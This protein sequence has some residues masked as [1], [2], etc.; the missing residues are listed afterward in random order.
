MKCQCGNDKFYGHQ[1][2]K[3]DVIV[4]RCGYF[5]ENLPGG[6]EAS[7][8]DADQPY[9]PF[10]CTKCEKEYVD[11]EIENTYSIFNMKQSDIRNMGMSDI[12]GV[13]IN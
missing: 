1:I 2:I 3:A 7:V 6:L 12:T 4:D 10:V 11:L 8:Y 9:G 13:A 5:H